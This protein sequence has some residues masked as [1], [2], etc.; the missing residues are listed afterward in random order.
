[1]IVQANAV[2]HYLEQT[3]KLKVGVVDITLFRPFPGDLLGKVLR[4]KKGVTVLERTDQPLAEDLPLMREVRASISK[5]IENGQAGG[6]P[7]P[8]PEYDTYTSFKDAHRSTPAPTAS[9]PATCSPR[10]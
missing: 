7:L 2:A 6:G 8:Y 10:G 3:R 5:C 4:G 9:A 1:M